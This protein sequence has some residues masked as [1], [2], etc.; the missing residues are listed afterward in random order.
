VSRRLASRLTSRLLA[1][2]LGIAVLAAPAAATPVLD[3]AD[4]VELAQALAEATAVQDVCY[5][6]QVDLRDDSGGPS[7]DDVGSSRGPDVALDPASCER[8]VLLEGAIHYTAEASEFEDDAA[9][10][11]S[12]NLTPAPTIADLRAFGV[13]GSL[14]DED[15]DVVLLNM[16]EALPLAVAGNGQAPYVEFETAQT[17]VAG[18]GEPTGTPGSDV[19]R[20]WWPLMVLCVLAILAGVVMLV[21]RLASFAAGRG[22]AAEPRQ[23]R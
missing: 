3:E 7:G 22:P 12:S 9:V 19:L 11:I 21:G 2:L 15:N 16:V 4:S 6:W 5:G 13:T 17:P 18:Q 8:W 23:G 1:G 20:Q 14:T 10:R